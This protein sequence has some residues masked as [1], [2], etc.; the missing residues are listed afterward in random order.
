MATSIIQLPNF[1]GMFTHTVETVAHNVA[2]GSSASATA[3]ITNAGW[4]PV[5]IAG[6]RVDGTQSSTIRVGGFSLNNMS[7]GSATILMNLYNSGSN[8]SNGTIY[9]VVLWQRIA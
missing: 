3:N 2:S 5:G 9:V 4:Y 1:R 6:W 7:Y 8:T